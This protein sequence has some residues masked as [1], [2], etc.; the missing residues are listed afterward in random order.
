M[1]MRSTICRWLISWALACLCVVAAA[2]TARATCGDYLHLRG[3]DAAPTKSPAD[4][5][6]CD[7]PNCSSRPSAPPL[8]PMPITPRVVETFAFVAV[9]ATVQ[10]DGPCG[11]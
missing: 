7:G 10:P 5:K 4:P 3:Q 1:S 2:S 9:L 6:P 11:V 8:A